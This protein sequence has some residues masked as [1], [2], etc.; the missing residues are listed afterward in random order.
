MERQCRAARTRSWADHGYQPPDSPSH[1]PTAASSARQQ[2]CR[3]RPVVLMSPHYVE[4]DD[5]HEQAALVALADLLAPYL[6]RPTTSEE[7]CA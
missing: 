3:Q 1:R 5:V 4:L 6:E 2:T 7:D